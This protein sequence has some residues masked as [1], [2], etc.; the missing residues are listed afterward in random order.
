[1]GEELP[2][3]ECDNRDCCSSLGDGK[4][5]MDCEDMN[6]W[7]TRVGCEEDLPENY[8]AMGE[9]LPPLEC[10]NRDCDVDETQIKGK[11][12]KCSECQ[13][14]YCSETCQR[15]DWPRHRPVW[16]AISAGT[17]TDY[18]LTDHDKEYLEG[19]GAEKLRA[20]GITQTEIDAMKSQP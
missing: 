8:P 9:E 16:A 12:K 13:A 11:M 14:P 4:L 3:L 1:M 15:M 18:G 20:M 10:D 7:R 17:N 6:A 5:V 2:P 19:G